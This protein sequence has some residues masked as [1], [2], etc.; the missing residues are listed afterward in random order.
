[1][2]YIIDY[3]IITVIV[4]VKQI[5]GRSFWRLFADERGV[6]LHIYVVV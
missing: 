4:I 6:V 1:M 5:M 2:S 3:Y